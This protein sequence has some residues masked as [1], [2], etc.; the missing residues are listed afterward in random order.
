VAK[1]NG[2]QLIEKRNIKAAMAYEMAWR[3]HRK[4][5]GG[6]EKYGGI[7]WRMS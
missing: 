5:R 6:G 2:R 1:E 3:R 7:S 4:W